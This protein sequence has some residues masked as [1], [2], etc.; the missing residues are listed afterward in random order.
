MKKNKAEVNLTKYEKYF[1]K[2]AKERVN[3]WFHKIIIPQ[4]ESELIKKEI[5]KCI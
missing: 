2:G 5:N 4:I 3:K 1:K